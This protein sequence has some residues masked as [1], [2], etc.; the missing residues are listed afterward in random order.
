MIRQTTD[1]D[2]PPTRVPLGGIR[3]KVARCRR[4]SLTDTS[5][6]LVVM[7]EETR[8]GAKPPKGTLVS[9]PSVPG[10]QTP[11]KPDGRDAPQS[12]EKR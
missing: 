10:V 2:N 3:G 6:R 1:D 9:N 5:R 4:A 8:G 7:S 11:K 12:G